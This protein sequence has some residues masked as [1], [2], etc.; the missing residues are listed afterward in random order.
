MLELILLE[1][2]PII[3]EELVEFLGDCGY[4][5]TLAS[6]IAT[7]NQVFEANR[8][9][10]AV[11]DLG[12][13]D[14]DGLE[15]IQGLRQQG[16]ALGII[17][18]TARAAVEQ[19][20]LGLRIGADH[21]LTKGCDLDEVAAVINTV[22]RRLGLQ[23][24][25]QPWRL[26]LRSLELWAP[27]KRGLRLSNQDTLVLEQLMRGASSNVSRRQIVEALGEDWLSYDQRRLDT[28]IRRL[29]R[30]VEQATGLELPL[31]T[32]RN[33]GYCFCARVTVVD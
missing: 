16:G 32:L 29:R 5:V 24:E 23:C 9:S 4:Q 20:V 10:L 30:K 17:A 28:R 6:D 33:N 31:K 3:A 12:L 15:L 22:V 7:F 21:Y 11:I 25:A 2:E 18:F 19:K 13:P 14:G 8:H 26:V 1:D 27:N